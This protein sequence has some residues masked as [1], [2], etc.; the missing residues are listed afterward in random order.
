M[1]ASRVQYAVYKTSG[2]KSVSSFLDHYDDQD[3]AAAFYGTVLPF[4]KFPGSISLN[5]LMETGR[6]LGLA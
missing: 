6:K 3:T 2:T 4:V 1:S 5:S